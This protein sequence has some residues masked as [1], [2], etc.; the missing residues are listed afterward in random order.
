[1]EIMRDDG[2]R[3]PLKNLRTADRLVRLSKLPADEA[4]VVNGFRA[5]AQFAHMHGD[6]VRERVFAEQAGALLKL[7]IGENHTAT[8][9]VRQLAE[10]PA[11]GAGRVNVGNLKAR[12]LT[13]LWKTSLKFC[14]ASPQA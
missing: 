11:G 4:C 3:P 12:R 7:A 2:M 5:T 9:C 10:D 1:M 8:Q 13:E 14:S 6:L